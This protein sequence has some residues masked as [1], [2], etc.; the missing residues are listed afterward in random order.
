MRFY[1]F[2]GKSKTLATDSAVRLHLTVVAYSQTFLNR[3]ARE[4]RKVL[5][6]FFAFLAGFAVN[7]DRLTDSMPISLIHANMI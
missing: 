3:E 4:A 7:L 2:R 6:V 1:V 5:K